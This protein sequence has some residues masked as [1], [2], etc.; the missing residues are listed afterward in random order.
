MAKI[1]IVSNP[2]NR[3]ISY[4]SFNEA[5]NAWVDIKTTGLNSRLREEENGKTFLPFKIKEIIDIIIE[6]YYVNSEMV[7]ILFEGT[8]DEYAEVESVCNE[9]GIKDKVSLSRSTTILENARFIFKET[10][11]IFET[12]HPIIEKIVKDDNQIVGSLN[13][14]SDALNDVIPICVFGNYSAGKSTFINALI[15][16]EVLPSGGDPVTA[17]IFKIKRS[18][19][20]DI[21]IIN[22]TSNEEKY[23]FAF[24][25]TSARVI[26]GDANGRIVQ[27][28]N[29]AI[30]VGSGSIVAMIK[31]ALEFLNGMEKKH[32][33][34]TVG[35]VIELEVPFSRNGIMGQSYNNYV[36]ID[37]PGSNTATYAEH[38]MVL[39]EALEGFSNGIPVWVSVYESID[40][41]D[42]A[43]LC[44]KIER[45]DALDK[46]F[47][48][49]ILNKADTSDLEED[50]FSK[51]QIQEILEYRAVEKMYSSGIYFVSSIM[52]LGAKNGGEFDDKHYG[53]TYRKQKEAYDD[54]EDIDYTTLF[55]YNIM[56]EQIKNSAMEYSEACTN[57][58]YA[59]SGLYCIEREIENFGSKHSAY[60]KCQ[61]VY[62]FLNN[63]IDETN[64]R[65]QSRTE[66]LKRTRAARETELEA[67]KK[68][69][70][71]SIAKE[72]SEM[73]REF[74]KGSKLHVRE[75]VE[76]CLD[77]SHTVEEID[78]IDKK[79]RTKN[80]EEADFS[81]HEKQFEDSVQSFWSHLRS[82]SQTLFEDKGKHFLDSVKTIKDDV[83]RDLKEMQESKESMDSA[84]RELD[85]ASSDTLLKGVVHEYKKNISKADEAISRE[86]KSYWY[87]L[88]Q[89]L[90]NRLAEIITDAEALSVAQREELANIII[91]YEPFAITDDADI[92]FIK[93]KFLRGYLFGFRLNDSEKLNTRLLTS[94]YNE[95]IKRNVY[96]MAVAINASYFESFKAWEK[97]LNSVIEENITDYNPQLRDMAA[98]IKEESEKILEL[99]SDQK[100]ICS[101]LEAI[102]ALMSWKAVE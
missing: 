21:A 1:K 9:E 40:S 65:I 95:K 14:V 56:P 42:N 41:D 7:E 20:E 30:Q 29:E 90:R 12:V 10:K 69:L 81:D 94:R 86:L 6:E 52:G 27:E 78:E 99:E 33:D 72:S 66:S 16:Y 100:S 85:K 96:D 70:I 26:K 76:E 17:K 24:E 63:V 92:V 22:F 4:A 60:N 77:Y 98:M 45:I 37:T 18:E 62:I 34:F 47:T 2:Y 80:F 3:E 38:A 83:V 101:S 5:A 15:G 58:I 48:M 87:E 67:S 84:E 28:L 55:K 44:E 49:I 75:Y 59:N 35:S 39:E 88:A 89:R 46:R 36:I 8:Q 71:D 19:Q 50:G 102:K 11:E 51:E 32:P 64:R 97:S 68:V 43:T 79:I 91:N 73:E 57:L 54:P 74:E 23:S 31:A 13:K 53:K 82:N 61:M 93:K 25:G